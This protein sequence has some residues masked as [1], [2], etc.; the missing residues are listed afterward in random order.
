MQPAMQR[1]ARRR[2]QVA[3]PQRQHLIDAAVQRKRTQEVMMI[4]SSDDPFVYPHSLPEANELADCI[5]FE[6]HAKGGH[7][8]FVDGSPRQ[9]GYYL[10][11]RIPQWLQAIE[12]GTQQLQ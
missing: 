12:R 9:P 7:V 3:A 8:G 1:L 6:L 5:R 10:E 4:Q 2:R 11:R